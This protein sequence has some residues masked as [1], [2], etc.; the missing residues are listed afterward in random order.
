M[1][2]GESLADVLDVG[3]QGVGEA[4]GHFIGALALLAE[5][6]ERAAETTAASKFVDA[7]A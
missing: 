4:G 5:Q 3:A 1:R 2:C 6:I 7:A